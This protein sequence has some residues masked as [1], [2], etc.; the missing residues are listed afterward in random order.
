MRKHGNGV[1][2]LSMVVH[3]TL[4][5]IY[6]EIRDLSVK[7]DYNYLK[8]DTSCSGNWESLPTAM[9]LHD[10]WHQALMHSVS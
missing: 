2:H 5:N 1:E 7:T 4:Q 6:L 10:L 9:L 8:N 3:T